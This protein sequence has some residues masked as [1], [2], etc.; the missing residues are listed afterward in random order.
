VRA[1]GAET[2]TAAPA[3]GATSTRIL[4]VDDNV[5]AA[6]TLG[7][8]LEVSGY[9]TQVVYD[10]QQALKALPEFRPHIAILDIGLPA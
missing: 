10:P 7:M 5:D 1:A 2:P 6:D 9:Q 4:V 8:L 3:P